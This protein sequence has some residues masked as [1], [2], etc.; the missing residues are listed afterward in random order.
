[1]NKNY[2]IYICIFSFIILNV[3]LVITCLKTNS[4]QQDYFRLHIVANSNSIDDQITKLKISK[5]V[6]NYI[7]SLNMENGNKENAK[8]IIQ[9][10]IGNILEI[11]NSELAK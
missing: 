3:F 8:E 6:T 10:N 5:K 11:A 7:S 4:N 9:N 1:M 2:C